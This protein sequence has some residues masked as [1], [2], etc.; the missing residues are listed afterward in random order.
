[1]EKLK[2]SIEQVKKDLD[3][4]LNNYSN[5]SLQNLN[6]NDLAK[7]QIELKSVL[8]DV[9]QLK[10][11]IGSQHDYIR[12]FTIPEKMNELGI[13]GVDINGVGKVMLTNTCYANITEENR[14]DAYQWL[15][16]NGHGALIKPTIN[17]NSLRAL[18][19]QKLEGGEE[20]PKSISV[21]EYSFTKVINKRY[22]D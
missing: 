20:I 8:T 1:M 9:D 13:K 17:N 16:D 11:T 10:K 5:E 7:L 21:H 22:I 19:R 14:E 3:D 18:I 6:I 12:K 15:E 2:K 4:F